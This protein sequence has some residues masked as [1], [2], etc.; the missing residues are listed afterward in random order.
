MNT[1]LFRRPRGF[2]L[3]ELLVV[4]AIIG[5]LAGLLLPVVAKARERGRQA[6]CLG[7]TRQLA[8]AVMMYATDNRLRLPNVANDWAYKTALQ[9]YVKENEAYACPSDRGAISYP[10]NVSEVSSASYGTSYMYPSADRAQAGVRGLVAS[11][12]GLK[13]TDANIAMSSKKV[14]L[15]EPPLNTLNDI[16]KTKT[17]WHSSKRVSVIGFLDG[18][19][20]L[21]LTNYSAINTNNLYY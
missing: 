1:H 20:E 12:T 19:S 2:T 9:P 21:V 10:G 13:L 14:A 5:I 15:F 3:I 4:I 8:A 11:G 16:T 18:H 6:K 7:N 17:Q